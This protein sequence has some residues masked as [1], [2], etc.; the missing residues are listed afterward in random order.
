[1]AS[2]N[3]KL[4][5]VD[6]LDT[7]IGSITKVDAHLMKTIKKGIFHRAF[8]VFIFDKQYRLLMQ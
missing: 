8:S 6:R 5:M 7:R 2:I 3:D 1:M 4:I